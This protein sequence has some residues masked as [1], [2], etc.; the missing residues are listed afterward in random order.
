MFFSGLWFLF[1]PLINKNRSLCRCRPHPALMANLF[2][3]PPNPPVLCLSSPPS[4]Q[5]FPVPRQTLL[6]KR[7]LT[8]SLIYL[9][10]QHKAQPENY[11]RASTPSHVLFASEGTRRKSW[12]RCE[13]WCVALI[14]RVQFQGLWY[15]VIAYGQVKRSRGIC[16]LLSMKLWEN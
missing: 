14:S 13:E 3:P 1:R 4:H 5:G 16:H 10:G 6:H 15:E 8:V 2:S 7:H 9:T 12:G 11:H